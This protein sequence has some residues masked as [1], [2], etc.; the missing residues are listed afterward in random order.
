MLR[1]LL[2]LRCETALNSYYV[3]RI[4]TPKS[5]LYLIDRKI[6]EMIWSHL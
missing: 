2:D 5:H 6:N 3:S 1:P 4:R